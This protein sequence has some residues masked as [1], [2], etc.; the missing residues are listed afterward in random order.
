VGLLV[1]IAILTASYV[2]LRDHF[3]NS[4]AD[5]ASE[6][7]TLHRAFLSAELEKY[8]Y[9]PYVLAH[10]PTIITALTARQPEL[11]KQVN[12]RLESFVEQSGAA[13]LYLMDKEGLTIASSNHRDQT[14][15]VGNNYSFRPYFKN[16][17]AGRKG[18]FFAVGVTTKTRGMFYAY[19]VRQ[20]GEIIGAMAAK[21]DFS[22]LE[23]SWREARE[24]VFVTD[25][26]G[27]VVLSSDPAHLYQVIGHLSDQDLETIRRERQ[28]AENEL[29][30][31]NHNAPSLL[32]AREIKLDD[33][34]YIHQ[35][36]SM[37]AQDWT[38]HYLTPSIA[39]AQ[40]SFLILAL[41]GL[42]LTSLL[43]LFLFLRG[44]GLK[45]QSLR[46]QADAKL[47]RRMNQ[48]LELEIDERRR[49]EKELRATQGNLIHA[50][51]MASLGHMS[52]TISHE[53][54]QHI[55]AAT[56]F[57]AGIKMLMKQNRST[58]ARQ[59]L[60]RVDDL[61]KRMTAITRQLKAFSR[62]SDPIHEPVHVRDA[63][64]S[65]ISVAETR[66]TALDIDIIIEPETAPSPI[67]IM[68]D[69]VQLEQVFLNIIQNAIDAVE[70]Q[71][72]RKIYFTLETDGN[73]AL[74]TCRDT[75]PGLSID[76]EETL[77]DPFITTKPHGDGLGLG[78]AISTKI[79]QNFEGALRAE[80]CAE[81][82][83]GALFSLSLPL[84]SSP[85]YESPSK[86]AKQA[87]SQ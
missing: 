18:A 31:M 7:L 32:G 35:T 79:I 6:R 26:R 74:I 51:K 75:G 87:P 46:A 72:V 71:E 40:S 48:R 29:R 1:V 44:R 10:D 82:G 15:F 45:R 34:T 13:A 56:T 55:A 25:R 61:M 23:Q 28:F 52:A 30:K 19:P 3:S 39:V 78:L 85:P 24:T 73:Q 53:I 68:G 58:E 21:V 50:S 60:D 54:N 11:S 66:L 16:A 36:R 65:A 70:S 43:A 2:Y 22:P 4:A 33:V 20:E 27:I 5:L 63:L 57:I 77:F 64:T 42:A 8:Q 83:Y 47:Q 76:I 81:E 59:T 84:V 49:T 17:M 80:N 41:E 69:R 14:S 37:P 67:Q 38:L 9:L 62:K 12:L 86:S